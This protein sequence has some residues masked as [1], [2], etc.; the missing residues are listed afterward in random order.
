LNLY[1][2]DGSSAGQFNL[3]TCGANSGFGT[4]NR[5]SWPFTVVS[6]DVTSFT[7]SWGVEN[8]T[9]ITASVPAKITCPAGGGPGA[10]LTVQ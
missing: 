10:T 2:A 3:M 7:G 5:M 1:Q 4:H 8:C 9:Q 6:F